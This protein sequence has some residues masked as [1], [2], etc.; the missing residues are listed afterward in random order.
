MHTVQCVF[1]VSVCLWDLLYIY[2][3]KTAFL[4][5][6]YLLYSQTIHILFTPSNL[7]S[8]W[9]S[10][11]GISC[12]GCDNDRDALFGILPGGDGLYIHTVSFVF[13]DGLHTIHTVRFVFTLVQVVITIAMPFLVF[14]LAE[15]AVT[16]TPCFL[17]S[18]RPFRLHSECPFVGS[19]VQVVIT[20]AMPFLVFLPCGDGLFI[21]TVSSVFTPS[22]CFVF[23]VS[24]AV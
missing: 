23:T 7:S 21:H 17:Y 12:K 4:F 8:Q 22:L 1:T 14:Y 2:L 24:K 5:T 6:P 3:A 16:F 11:C 20:I 10:V 9:V 15:T 18:H 13:T 19:L